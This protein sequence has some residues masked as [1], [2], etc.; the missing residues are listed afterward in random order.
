[1]KEAELQLLSQSIRSIIINESMSKDFHAKESELPPL[2]FGSETTN[3]Q[4]TKEA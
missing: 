3:N 2:K 4:A 1:M